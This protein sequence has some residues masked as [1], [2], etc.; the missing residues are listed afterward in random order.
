MVLV[1]LIFAIN[2]SLD[3]WA[4]TNQKIYGVKAVL[5][6]FVIVG[7]IILCYYSFK[8]NA[9]WISW[10][11]VGYLVIFLLLAVLRLF[12]DNS[13]LVASM[14]SFSM[15]VISFYIHSSG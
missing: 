10:V 2:F 12:D 11:N 14:I 3:E 13:I 7:S 4:K 6:A 8:H 5:V 1:D 15:I 9:L